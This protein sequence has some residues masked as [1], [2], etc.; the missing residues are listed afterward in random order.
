M[1]HVGRGSVVVEYPSQ[2]LMSG[3]SRFRHDAN[4]QGEYEELYTLS[5]RHHSL[6][7]M[8]GFASRIKRL[9]PDEGIKDE[10]VPMPVPDIAKALEGVPE[11]WHGVVKDAL[12]AG[13]GVV[14]IPEMFGMAGLASAI[15]R[16]FPRDALA[17]RGTPLTVVAARDRDTTRRIAFE[18]RRILPDRDVGIGD[19]DSEDILVAQYGVCLEDYP[20]QSVG[21]LIGDDVACEDPK[22]FVK[23]A[24]HVSVFRNAARWGVYE[25]ACGG[26]P[27]EL[28]LAA[29]GLFGPLSASATYDDAVRA[30]VASPVTVCWL[31]APRPKVNWG[32]APLKTLAS[33]AMGKEFAEVVA[34]IVGRTSGDT[35]CIV[36]SDMQTQK[37]LA[38]RVVRDGP[39]VVIN[40]RSAAKDVKIMFDDMAI[41]NIPR[42]MVT[43]DRFPPATSHGVMV[44]ATCGGREVAGVRF[45]WR[46]SGKSGKVYIV[47]FNHSWDVHNGRPGVLAR[48][49]AARRRRYSELGF[50]QLSVEDVE[51]L[52]FVG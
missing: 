36:C 20:M 3:L 39:C 38:G 49:D 5:E 17:E 23:R 31:E 22:V 19:C 41:G 32:S 25:T 10:R 37:A 7:T 40:R 42:A 43:W 45:P 29:E 15:A 24:R 11:V 28:D 13:G 44:S 46:G 1:I 34:D 51:H 2:E 33:I 50:S 6:V 26:G 9:C 18:M 35:G 48:N 21:I 27:D 16:A 30:G 52:P 4:G 8:P 14:A 47:D 12:A